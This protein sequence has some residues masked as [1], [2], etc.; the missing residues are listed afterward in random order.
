MKVFFSMEKVP[1]VATSR[2]QTTIYPLLETSARKR[3]RITS[4]II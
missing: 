3:G 1:L 4:Y 2:R